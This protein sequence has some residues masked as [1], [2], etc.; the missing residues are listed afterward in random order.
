MFWQHGETLYMYIN[1]NH[2]P[3]TQLRLCN[4]SAALYFTFGHVHLL[5]WL[6][7]D[8]FSP[9]DRISC[10]GGVNPVTST[11]AERLLLDLAADFADLSLRPEC[12]F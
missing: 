4:H 1:V 10:D 9:G 3:Y 6:F 12:H 2:P 11:G 7:N 5:F 8:T